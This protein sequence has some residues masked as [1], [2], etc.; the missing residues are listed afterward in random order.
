MNSH[1]YIRSV[2]RAS[3]YVAASL[4]A[5]LS[6][7]AAADRQQ[8]Q[9]QLLDH[10]EFLCSNCLLGASDYYY[11]FAADNKILIGY[12]RTRVLNWQDE[13]KNYLTGV[14]G[15]WAAWTAPGQTVP[16]SYDDKHIWVSRA[17]PKQVRRGAWAQAK[18]VGRWV[19]RADSKQVRLT[20]SPL[21]DIF[22]N[23]DRCRNADKPKAR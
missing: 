19:I 23:N 10:A 22:T 8:V 17:E 15:G 11:C 14:H 7:G 21:R 16:I 3:V 12:Q 2:I 20:Q 6:F 18:A 4:A 5:S 13:T 1:S 9:A